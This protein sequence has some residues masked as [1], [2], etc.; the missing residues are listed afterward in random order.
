MYQIELTENFY[1]EITARE[2]KNSHF[3]A[4]ILSFLL[5]HE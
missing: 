3:G 5:V 2:K 4:E 1:A